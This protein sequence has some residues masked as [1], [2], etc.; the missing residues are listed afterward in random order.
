M[1][2]FTRDTPA[3][4]TA[5]ERVNA[6]IAQTETA[7]ATFTVVVADLESAASE[8]DDTATTAHREADYH[9]IVAAN[10]ENAAAKAR[11]SADKVRTLLG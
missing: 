11:T 4:A 6:A 7:L 9:R 5:A 10:A 1:P 2:L 8:L 3:P